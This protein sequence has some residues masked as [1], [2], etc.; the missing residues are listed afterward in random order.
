M[1]KEGTRSLHSSKEFLKNGRYL[2]TALK[3]IDDCIGTNTGGKDKGVSH[4][5]SRKI[6]SNNYDHDGK[7]CK[8][9]VTSRYANGIGDDHSRN[10]SVG[11]RSKLTVG[12]HVEAKYKGIS[13]VYPGKITRCHV[14]D[15]Y[16]ILYGTGEREFRVERENIYVSKY[17]R[18]C[19]LSKGINVSGC[20]PR[21][22]I[23]YGIVMGSKSGN[24]GRKQAEFPSGTRVEARYRGKK[25]YYAGKITHVYSKDGTYDIHYEDGDSEK[26]VPKNLIRIIEDRT[27]SSG[28]IIRRRST[29]KRDSKGKDK[30]EETQGHMVNREHLKLCVGAR[31]NA[32]YKGKSKFYPGKVTCCRS[33]GTYDIL[34]DDGECEFALEKESVNVYPV[35]IGN[36]KETEALS[37]YSSRPQLHIGEPVEAR[38]INVD[39][40]YDMKYEGGD[41]NNGLS[42]K[43]VTNITTNGNGAYEREDPELMVGT[44]VEARFRRKTRYYPGKII[45]VHSKRGTYDIDYDDG[46]REKDVSKELIRANTMSSYDASCIGKRAPYSNSMLDEG[47]TVYAMFRGK[48]T[49]WNSGTVMKVRHDGS[50]D[51]RFHF[52]P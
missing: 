27:T 38:Y 30:I 13:Q 11:S 24:V 46:D 7:E 34:Y 32:K 23:T 19:P 40:T 5:A 37:D 12:T 47:E 2:S 9:S 50:C 22:E 20:S 10:D 25:R 28:H 39:G 48:G 41:T 44:R 21:K 51:V 3:Q 15:T 18:K 16:D 31:V 14:N 45:R 33:D 4:G 17:K 1:C 42:Y 36:Q 26:H 49:Q 43:N 35:G 52:S 29:E 6:S 8:F